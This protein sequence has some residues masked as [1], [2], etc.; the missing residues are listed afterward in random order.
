MQPCISTETIKRI[1]NNL[2]IKK[3]SSVKFRLTLPIL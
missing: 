2:E 3:P 1:I